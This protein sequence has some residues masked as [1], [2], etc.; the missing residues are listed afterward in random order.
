M[1]GEGQRFREAG[2]EK[3]K[4]LILVDGKPIIQYVAEL[5]RPEDELIFVVSREHLADEKHDLEN[6]LKRIRPDAKIIAVEPKKLGPNYGILGAAEFLDET[7]VM[8]S[9]CDFNLVWDRA[10]F[11]KKIQERQ[12]ASAA[13]CYKGF[14]PHL[15]QPNLYAGVRVD[16]QLNALEVQE[17]T[18]FTE[19]KMETWQQAGL[20]YFSSGKLLKEYCERAFREGWLLNGESYTSL[21]FTPMI[22]DSLPSLVYP[23]E[24]FCQWGTPADLE[25]YEAWSQLLAAEAGR[26]KGET[27][28][29]TLRKKQ[30]RIPWPEDS[31]EYRQSRD[32]WKEYF[33]KIL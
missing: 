20:F 1:S 2:Y 22:N 6:I 8:V 29:P 15:L 28:I 10:D 7:P 3:L 9:Y 23:A 16:D 19:N 13:I 33:Q 32:Y 30:L 5:F 24:F 12:P 11:E 31:K 17:K 26:I 18:S 21:L 4:P 14:H 25:E 27:D